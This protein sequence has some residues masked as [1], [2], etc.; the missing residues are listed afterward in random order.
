VDAILRNIGAIRQDEAGSPNPGHA[1]GASR[2]ELQVVLSSLDD[3]Q[4][5]DAVVIDLTG[6]TTIADAMIVASGRSARHVGSMAEHLV[7]RLKAAGIAVQ[8]EGQAHAD[9]ILIDA[10]DVIVHLFRPEVRE[11]YALEKMWGGDM[12][13]AQQ[14]RG[15]AAA[16]LWH[17]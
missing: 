8:V 9:W 17:A 6:K 16:G 5:Q 1:A 11:F 3:D 7:E 10:G 14:P 2:F 13:V 15:E 12:P 4:A